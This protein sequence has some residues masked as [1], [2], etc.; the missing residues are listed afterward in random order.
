MGCPGD[1]HEVAGSGEGAEASTSQAW[2]SHCR[3]LIVP[4]G[5]VKLP[6]TAAVRSGFEE[7]TRGMYHHLL[8]P[9]RW[10]QSHANQPREITSARHGG[11]SELVVAVGGGNR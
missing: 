7:L 8:L 6:L 3:L 10:G 5:P 1:S 11:H 4:G 2:I 9:V